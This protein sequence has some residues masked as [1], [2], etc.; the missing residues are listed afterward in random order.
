MWFHEHALEHDPGMTGVRLSFALSDWRDLGEVYP[1][2]K[3]AF[4]ET[5]D[6]KTRQLEEGRGSPALFQDVAE[7]NRTFGANAATVRLFREIGK[8]NPTLAARCW[9]FARR[10]VFAEKQYDVAKQYLK[11]PLQEYALAKA[12]YDGIV[13]RYNA[14][15]VGGAHYRQWLDKHF[16]EE[17]LEL[18]E[19]A[20]VV[21]DKPAAQ[22]IRKRAASVIGDLRLRKA[23]KDP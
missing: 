23:H 15:P 19:L 9:F 16:V 10:A 11:S 17:C 21:G 7:L 8:S 18:I 13:A 2:A 6:R 22:Q 20:N 3:Q 5:R 4:I 1:P 14:S 12:R